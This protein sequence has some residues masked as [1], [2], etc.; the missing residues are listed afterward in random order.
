M[1]W[2][3]FIIQQKLTIQT[4]LYI[5][6]TIWCIPSDSIGK[7]TDKEHISS[8]EGEPRG[9]INTEPTNESNLHKPIL[10][11]EEKPMSV[12]VQ[13][14][15]TQIVKELHVVLD[16]ETDIAHMDI[17]T[18]QIDTCEEK[19]GQDTVVPSGMTHLSPTKK[20][21]KVLTTKIL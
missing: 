8:L 9:S 10:L 11:W 13:T 3:N 5:G 18:S 1:V 19:K 2:G 17:N 12:P 16:A 7:E 14:E 15:R 6:P 20:N 21:E 4:S